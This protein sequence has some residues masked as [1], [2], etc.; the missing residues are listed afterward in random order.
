M[1]LEIIKGYGEPEVF[2]TYE[3]SIVVGR[4][5]HVEC[6]IEE[7]GVSREHLRLDVEGSEV[8]VTDLDSSNGSYIQGQRLEPNKKQLWPPLFPLKMGKEGG[9]YITARYS[10][11]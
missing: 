6:C 2:E 4:A 5:G 8:Y 7:N 10:G 1:R 11:H 3:W 9:Y